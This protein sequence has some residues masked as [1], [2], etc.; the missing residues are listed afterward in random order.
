MPGFGPA[1]CTIKAGA[2][3]QLPG[4]PA[5]WAQAPRDL[6]GLRG[7]SPLKLEYGV[8]RDLFAIFYLLKEDYRDLGV[9]GHK[10]LE[11]YVEC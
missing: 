1:T 11:V 6:Q 7:F 9:L 4:G 8:Y 2:G 5:F 3:F 10:S